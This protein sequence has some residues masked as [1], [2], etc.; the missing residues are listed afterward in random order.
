M[1]GTLHDDG[2]LKLFIGANDHP[3][4]HAHVYHGPLG[5]LARFRFSYLSNQVELYRFARR[6]KRPLISELNAAQDIVQRRLQDCREE[7]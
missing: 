1:P 7:W 6:G 2:T 3:P 5:W 4:P